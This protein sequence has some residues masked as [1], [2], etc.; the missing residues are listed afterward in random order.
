MALSDTLVPE[1]DQEMA[2]TRKALERVPEDKFDWQPHPKSMKLGRLAGHLAEIPRW[3]AM[4]IDKDSYDLQPPG[5]PP[6]KPWFPSGRQEVLDLFDKNVSAGR[7]ALSG[8]SD[9]HL[10]KPWSLLFSEKNVFTMPRAGV[11]RAMVLSHTIHHR[12]QLGV[13]LRLNDVPVPATYGPSA[14]EQIM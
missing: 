1:F 7:Q 10:L 12:A 9:E 6:Y 2:N 13:Y 3:V 5:A 4:A 11:L 14:D 8:A